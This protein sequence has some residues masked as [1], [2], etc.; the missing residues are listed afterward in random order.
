MPAA[1]S[2]D[3]LMPRSTT[4][5]AVGADHAPV[6]VD[7]ECALGLQACE[8]LLDLGPRKRTG[9][10]ELRR[11]CRPIVEQ[12]RERLPPDFDDRITAIAHDPRP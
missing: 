9:R 6:P 7:L 12:R 10:G 8:R 4:R 11:R 2:R 1:L 5:Q 3:D